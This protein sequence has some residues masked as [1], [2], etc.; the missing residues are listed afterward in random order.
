MRGTPVK[1]NVKIAVM[2]SCAISRAWF[3]L[4]QSEVSGYLQ[5]I[6]SLSKTAY[7]KAHAKVATQLTNKL[8]IRTSHGEHWALTLPLLLLN[9]MTEQ[10]NSA[11]SLET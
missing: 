10:T 4:L 5:A 11:P 6:H 9:S 1:R 7:L 2:D 8:I 3:I